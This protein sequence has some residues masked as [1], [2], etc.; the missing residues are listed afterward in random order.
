M[1]LQPSIAEAL[2]SDYDRMRFD[3]ATSSKFLD[4]GS[5]QAMFDAFRAKFGPAVLSRLS[6]EDLLTAMH[7]REVTD[8]LMYWLE[9]KNDE[10]FQTPRF[11]S[12]AGGSALKFGL[13]QRSADGK[14]V[15]GSPQHQDVIGLDEAIRLATAQRDALLT[16]YEVVAAAADGGDAAYAALQSRLD[17]VNR[18]FF[19]LA[20]VHKYLSVC[21]PDRIDDYHATHYQHFHLV[22]LLIEPIASEPGWGRYLN[23]GKYRGIAEQLEIEM[24]DL[25]QFL[26][27]RNGS[28]HQWLV[29]DL[30]RLK[31]EREDL[32][33]MQLQG[34]VSPGFGTV[35]DLSRIPYSQEGRA[36]IRSMAGDNYM[37]L[38]RF[39]HKSHP[40]DVAVVVS[41]GRTV[42]VAELNGDYEY[43]FGGGRLRHR[44]TAR[45]HEWPGESRAIAS[46]R[47][48][49][50]FDIS[51]ARAPWDA[52]L[53]ETA[54][55]QGKPTE[56]V[57]V[58]DSLS[59]EP[60]VEVLDG[61]R[62]KIQQVLERR[63]QVILYGPP[64][65]GKTYWAREAARELAARHNYGRSWSK[66]EPDDQSRI[67]GG[68]DCFVRLC[69][70]HP[71]Y[72]YEDFIEGFRPSVS[73]GQLS[74]R[75]EP[76]VFK[77][78]CTDA[79]E[80]PENRY[81]LIID[82]I[83]RGDIARIFGELITLVEADKR[84]LWPAILPLS[85]EQFAVP[86]NLHILGT[87]NTA[88]KSIALLDSALRR[89]FGFIELMP[90]PE[91]LDGVSV[92][93]FRIGEFLRQLN[94]RITDN[95]G[96]DGRSLQVGHAYFMVEGDPITDPS[97]FVSIFTDE[98]FPLVQEYCYNR[99]ELLAQ[100][101]GDSL[102]DPA[103]GQ[104]KDEARVTTDAFFDALYAAFPALAEAAVAP[105]AE[106]DIDGAEGPAV[107]DESDA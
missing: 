13:Y 8:S 104:V 40:H 55:Q 90:A 47:D 54:W 7:G 5:R 30:D 36:R 15:T 76:G 88:D 4:P 70:F 50:W 21:F 2:G 41:G 94:R 82:E 77:R 85:K 102:V 42:A 97:T 38:W 27:I 72:G 91:L 49:G 45:W 51:A 99:R 58:P 107:C 92:G 39:R 32:A 64:G 12:I 83:N 57:T 71:S 9:F 24:N 46:G 69:T 65:T 84:G 80:D 86:S 35:D 59:P 74:F 20:W 37:D 56:S 67:W 78:L 22:K 18:D 61:L 31:M 66:L 11:G 43:Y 26:N 105:V 10:V 48:A 73:D 93:S 29:V 53:V 16:G 17:G 25:T 3:P 95:L 19:S 62:G 81:Y 79:S 68:Q 14:W 6:G 75:L 89:R 1:I 98:V 106:A 87:M 52:V 63:K 96:D 100:V 23:A 33:A 44:M 34:I 60:V 28:P 103:T 101:F